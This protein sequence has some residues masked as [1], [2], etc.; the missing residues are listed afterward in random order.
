MKITKEQ[1][2]LFSKF[3]SNNRNMT[4]EEMMEISKIFKLGKDE[5]IKKVLSDIS[6]T[7][8]EL[9]RMKII[10]AYM[11]LSKDL[12]EEQVISKVYEVD[13]KD[14]EHKFLAS[15]KEIIKF[16]SNK[17]NRIEILEKEKDGKDIK[18]SLEEKIKEQEGKVDSINLLEDE[19]LNGNNSVK[20]IPIS[21]IY[22]YDYLVDKLKA[23]E[24]FALKYLIEN[25]DIL[26][27]EYI[28]IENVFGVST[29]DYNYEIHESRYDIE[30]GDF[31]IQKP[32]E[33]VKNENEIEQ[34]GNEIDE[35]KEI[36]EA[37]EELSQDAVTLYKDNP[38]L[39]ECLNAEEKEKVEKQIEASKG[40]QKVKAKPKA[41]YIDP[42]ILALITG[43]A[44]GVTFV[45]AF[46]KLK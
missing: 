44:G 29:S 36:R 41:G 35:E 33:E 1:L 40:Y 38:E 21:K 39:V 37:L 11:N 24:L 16:Y 10:D 27:L 6:K 26:H 15:G 25:K 45:V 19:R 3:Q 9:E 20:L 12:T 17:T 30:R 4:K 42:L 23:E 18:D 22:E 7:K 14:I 2:I 13:I 32:E 5:D 43:F 34:L 31:I 28:N 46:L 8:N